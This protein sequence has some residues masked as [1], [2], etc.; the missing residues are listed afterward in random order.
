MFVI[1]VCM[2]LDNFP[3]WAPSNCFGAIKLVS[4]AAVLLCST[5]GQAVSLTTYRIYL[6]DNNR[7]ESFI[8]FTRGTQPEKCDLDFK[9]FDFDSVGKMTMNQGT[10]LPANAADDWVRYS[11]RNFV[12][13]PGKPQT[14]RFSMRRKPNTEAAEYRSYI[15]IRCE[16]VV[17]DPVASGKDNV[18]VKDRVQMNVKP[19]LVQNVP[20]IIRTGSLNVSASISDVV[21]GGGKITAKLNRSGPRSIYGRVSLVDKKSDEEYAFTEAVSVY[22]ETSTYAFEFALHADMPPL[23]QLKLK[24]TED[25]NYGGD[26]TIE[27]S[28][29]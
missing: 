19:L 2:K 26:L 3:N 18:V 25:E 1:E 10:A 27:K 24:F 8:V 22:P 17:N 4:L 29:K 20:L 14:I 21:V 28:V 13:Q 7:T 15:A 9:H 16:D 12:V 23:E 11:P 5:A 6:D